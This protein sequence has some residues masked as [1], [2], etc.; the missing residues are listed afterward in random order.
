[1]IRD[2]KWEWEGEWPTAS[3]GGART[4]EEGTEGKMDR[5]NPKKLTFGRD[6]G[7]LAVRVD[8]GLF[9]KRN[10]RRAEAWRRRGTINDDAIPQS[11]LAHYGSLRFEKY[12]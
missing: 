11:L 9:A 1:M 5:K 7:K 3:E 8:G 4:R 10:A 2:G 6:G 12:R